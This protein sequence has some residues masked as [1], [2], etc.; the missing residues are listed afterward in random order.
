MCVDLCAMISSSS[1]RGRSKKL[2]IR[3]Q[4]SAF[5]G[6]N[7]KGMSMGV[8]RRFWKGLDGTGN[9]AREANI[10]TQW[11]AHRY[12]HRETASYVKEQRWPEKV[13]VNRW[14][15]I[16]RSIEAKCLPYYVSQQIH[17]N[18]GMTPESSENE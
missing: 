3:R 5:D 7:R 6:D 18:K 15:S 17:A 2:S 11:D 4:L 13:A 14:D 10:V 1:F 12:H 16:Q 9:G 8:H